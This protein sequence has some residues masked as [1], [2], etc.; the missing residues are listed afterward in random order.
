MRFT[1]ASRDERINFRVTQEE[2]DFLKR[3]A[4]ELDNTVAGVLRIALDFWLDAQVAGGSSASG[5]SVSGSSTVKP[6]AASA[7]VKAASKAAP[8]K[9]KGRTQDSH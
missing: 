9:K 7:K 4:S 2:N 1:E 6:S 5:S 3:K 8:S